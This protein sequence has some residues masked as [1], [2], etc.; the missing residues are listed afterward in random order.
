M[1]RLFSFILFIS[2]FGSCQ[3]ETELPAEKYAR[4]AEP[5]VSIHPDSIKVEGDLG[6]FKVRTS[7]SEIGPNLQV[8][9]YTFKADEPSELQ[10]VT[11]HLRFPSVD[12]NGF[13]NPKY[14]AD[15]VSYYQ[16]IDSK[17][18]RWMPLFCY[19]NDRL[20][21]RLTVALD[22]ALNHTEFRTYVKEEDVHFNVEMKLFSEKMPKT[23]QYEIELRIDTRPVPY[24]QS[25][26]DVA[27][28]WA[29]MPQYE[30]MPVPD[31]ARRPMY[32]TWYS[33][34][35][36]ITAEEIVAE[37]RVAKSLGCEAVIVDDG[38]QTL[39]GNRG[40]AFTGDWLPER[41]PNMRGF[42]DSVH[43]TGM[44]FLLW[45][46][47][48][49]MGEKA[50]NYDRF[51][52][53][54]LRY[55]DGQG[56]YVLDPRYPEVREYIINTYEKALVDWNL[57]GFKL[58][59]IG[60]F[61]ATEDTDLT[62]RDGRDF[63]SVNEAT[64][65]LMTQIMKRLLEMKPD[66][67]IEFR[68]PYVGPLMR[69]YGNLFRGVDCPNN[70]VSNRLEITNLRLHS[71]NTA[72][73][74]DMFIWRKEEPVESAALQILNILYSVPQLSVRLEEMPEDHL[75]M[76]RYWFAYWNENRDILLDGEFIPS[77]PGANYPQLTAFAEGQQITTVYEEVLVRPVAENWKRLD[78]INAKGSSALMIELAQN[79]TGKITV[80][81]CE[82]ETLKA[83]NISLKK[84][85]HGLTA[86]ASGMVRLE[87]K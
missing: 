77:N 14:Y 57:D 13:W 70:A 68:Q 61:T 34:H 64:D 6:A 65:Y 29:S 33:Y 84:G 27:A 31:I 73:H 55:W 86:P 24:H 17:A 50:K 60:R 40:Y 72:V 2:V 76:I 18:S 42:V 26:K 19:H 30:P 85:F 52:G 75:N 56:T 59:F 16:N 38:W 23:D 21:N 87:R 1:K 44:K 58:D 22:D 82:G 35:Q 80:I 28:W 67:M 39:D 7:G 78:L 15:K 83:E 32:S 54:Y 20:Q 36:S 45:Y 43:A 41:I 79:F 66:I 12:V 49:F 37:C 71:G 51:K 81:D 62:A 47:L 25:V 3:N 8:I 10:P 4:S 63:A 69:K 48:P 46:S 9:K 5:L 11:L 53:K 74:S